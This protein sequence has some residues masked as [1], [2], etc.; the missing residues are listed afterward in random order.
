MVKTSVNMYDHLC[1]VK[2]QDYVLCICVV[3]TCMWM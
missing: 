2:T 3:E 1:V